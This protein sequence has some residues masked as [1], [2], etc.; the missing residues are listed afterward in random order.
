MMHDN[1]KVTSILGS[2]GAEILWVSIDLGSD[3]M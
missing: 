1:Y 3:L 2:L